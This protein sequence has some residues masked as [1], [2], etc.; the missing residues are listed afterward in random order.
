MTT[1]EFLSDEWFAAVQAELAEG[2]PELPEA[3]AGLV[4][5]V[6]VQDIGVD[7]TYRGC[8]WEPGHSA[9]AEA[10]LITTKEL[11]YE[12]M[13]RKNIPLGVRAISTGK[14]KIKGNRTKLMKL[15]VIKPSA[16]QAA[17]EQ[18]VAAFT[19]VQRTAV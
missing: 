14:A 16:S 4:M 8:W 19:E 6:V 7:C 13:V 5:N 9:D 3:L 2:P 12:V 10:T 17:F 15:R 11:A 1:H 18:R